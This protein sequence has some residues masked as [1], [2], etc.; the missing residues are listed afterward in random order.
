MNNLAT[1]PVN[2]KHVASKKIN[3]DVLSFCCV[4]KTL[5]YILIFQ[6]FWRASD[7]VLTFTI[8]KII[9]PWRSYS[10]Y[11]EIC[12]QTQNVMCLGA[13]NCVFKMLRK[14]ELRFPLLSILLSSDELYSVEREREI[15]YGP[16]VL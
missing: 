2:L 8:S 11:S 5:F 16:D 1:I 6:T 9:F 14:Q 15:I 7:S 12:F 13:F 10:L 3:V 4:K